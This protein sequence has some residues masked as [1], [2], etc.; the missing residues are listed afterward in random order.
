[1][2][3]H[4]RKRRRDGSDLAEHA[5][6]ADEKLSEPVPQ[7]VAQLVAPT[8]NLTKPGTNLVLINYFKT[9]KVNLVK[10]TMPSLMHPGRTAA[11]VADIGSI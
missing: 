3:K 5:H 7:L 1:M 4:R 2:S 11:S 8:H 10:S 6:P 9:S